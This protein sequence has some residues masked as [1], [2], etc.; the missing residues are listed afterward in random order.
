[1]QNTFNTKCPACHKDQ[2]THADLNIHLEKCE[3]YP[4][5][6]KTYTV[7]ITKKCEK[8]ERIFIKEYIEEHI[9]NCNY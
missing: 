9:L 7:P 2:Q 8:C 1:M 4:E 3:K 6:Y 5:W